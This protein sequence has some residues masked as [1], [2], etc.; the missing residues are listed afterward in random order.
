MHAQRIGSRIT[1]GG[2]CEGWLITSFLRD[3]ADLLLLSQH[4]LT[5]RNSPLTTR[6]TT[7]LT[8]GIT[9]NSV[10]QPFRA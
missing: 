5:E 7:R 6:M 2:A 1:V 9:T 3:N 8:T 4:R 10:A